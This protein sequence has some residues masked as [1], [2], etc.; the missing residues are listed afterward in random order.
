MSTDYS[1]RIDSKTTVIS[2]V[3]S[4]TLCNDPSLS[5]K[6]DSKTTVIS[7]YH[8]P[9]G[10]YKIESVRVSEP[11]RILF[12]RHLISKENI[13]LKILYEYQDSRYNL[14]T[15]DDRQRCQ[16]EALHWNRIFTPNIHIGLAHICRLDHHRKG[17][18]I[19]EIIENPNSETLAPKTDYALLMRQLPN[20]RRLDYI[21]AE[22]K[23]TILRHYIHF[24][25]KYIVHIHTNLAALSISMGDASRWGS[26]VQ[27]QNKLEH[28]LEFLDQIIEKSY[29]EYSTYSWLKDRL[30]Q[31]FKLFKDLRYFEQRV[32]KGRIKRCHADLKAPNIWIDPLPDAQQ[33]SFY[34]KEHWKDNI[35]LL[36]AIDF[37]PMYSY[38]DILSDFAMLVTDIH[39]RT[40]SIELANL[41]IEE[42]LGLTNQQDTVSRL[43]LAYYLVEKAIIGAAV[44]ILYDNAPYVGLDFLKTAE[45][46]FIDLYHMMR[47]QSQLPV[48]YSPNLTPTPLSITH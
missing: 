46:R 28:N 39:A 2:S 13:V 16:L 31:V 12:A 7:P 26:F 5:S 34:D 43:V 15:V 21:I 45:L 10:F 29:A 40:R 35:Y 24:L 38:I 17:I 20:S 47:M 19:D 8:P 41:M 30:I 44:S 14:A 36:D 22:E 42:Y 18:E 4:A 33:K 9:L 37:N 23:S 32:Q 1:S 27:L 48:I 25:T 3:T 6:I 11:A